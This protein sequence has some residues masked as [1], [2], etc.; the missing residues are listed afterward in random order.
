MFKGV[1]S[2]YE[3]VEQRGVQEAGIRL[4]GLGTV[5]NMLGKRGNRDLLPDFA[6]HLEVFGNLVQVAAELTGGGWPVERRVVSDC[7]KE[8]FAVGEILAVLA[9]TFPREGCLRVG[10]L[11]D[12][13]L[14]AFI[15]P[16]GGAESNQR[17]ARHRQGVYED[18]EASSMRRRSFINLR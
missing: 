11:V 13:A 8:R 15:G 5:A 2:Q 18:Q 12:L 14:P 17:G 6:A 9:Q 10:L 3:I 1:R 7:A 16:R 4:P